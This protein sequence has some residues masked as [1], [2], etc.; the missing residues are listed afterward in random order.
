ML[1]DY[2]DATG[3]MIITLA[4]ELDA[5]NKQTI[6]DQVAAVLPLYGLENV[7]LEMSDVTVLDTPALEAMV[8]AQRICRSQGKRLLVR[9]PSHCVEQVLR[10]TFT[11]PLFSADAIEGRAP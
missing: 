11:D 4:G 10:A 1:L 9:H 2:E 5:S 7:A 8:A 6:L 3:T